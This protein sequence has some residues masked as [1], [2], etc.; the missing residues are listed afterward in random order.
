MPPLRIATRGSRLAR[1]QVELV[2]ELL[3]V[4]VEPVVVSTAG[5]RLSS[6][7]LRAIAGAGAFAGDVR[8]AL[9]AGAADLA[10]HS[11]KDLPPRP[12]PRLDIVAFPPR[13][14]ARDALVGATLAGLP[15]GAVIGT[16]APRRRAQLA[17]LRPDVN[18]AEL[19]GNIDTRLRR[20]ADLDA[21][22]VAMA[23]LHRLGIVPDCVVQPL[24]VDEMVP[25]VG[26]G[27]LAVEARRDDRA[28]RLLVSRIDD[29]ATR[30]A[31][32]AERA[33]LDRLGGD[34]D[35]P[36]G[37]HATVRTDGVVVIDSV[38]ADAD[39]VLHR[40]STRGLDPVA[41]GD[42]AALALL[43]VIRVG[44]RPRGRARPV[45]APV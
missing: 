42:E 7:P 3:G 6:V 12:D 34:C 35:L 14:D 17:A 38:L 37:A 20:A 30:A 5:D 24:P 13:A 28:M 8:D 18:F 23:A 16:G 39:G 21:V 19:R 4:R 2:S 9:V 11:A 22:V 44:G 36:A 1:R 45:E 32:T 25:Q 33:F 27:A 26:Q 40:V 15:R 41:A 43:D 31:V 10:V 29:G